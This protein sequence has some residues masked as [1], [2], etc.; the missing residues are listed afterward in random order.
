MAADHPPAEPAWV[1]GHAHEPNPLPPPGDGEFILRTPLGE[2][3]VFAVAALAALPYA[4]AAGCLIVS[5]GHGASGPFT[6]GG[7]RLLDLLAHA[8]GLA[9]R[10]AAWLAGWRWVDVISTDGFGTRL[11]PEDLAAAGERPIVLAW[12]RDGLLL[13]RA[14]G[15]VRLVVPTEHDDALRQVKWVARIEIA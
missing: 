7:V 10:Q 9:G 15:L 12:R 11:T 5:T 8:A 13:T 14:Q 6:F 4:E 1:H 2:E 3:L